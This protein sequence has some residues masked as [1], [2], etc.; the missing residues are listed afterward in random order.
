MTFDDLEHCVHENIIAMTDDRAMI[1]VQVTDLLNAL[2]EEDGFVVRRV[3]KDIAEAIAIELAVKD[4]DMVSVIGTLSAA[5]DPM[6]AWLEHYGHNGRSLRRVTPNETQIH[7]RNSL[8]N[9]PPDNEK[10]P[11]G[12]FSYGDVRNI[13]SEAATDPSLGREIALK[14][15]DRDGG[16]AKNASS[17]KPEH[18][19]RVYETF[20]RLL[21]RER[22]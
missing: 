15:L 14:V 8:S 20:E 19:D 13:V 10:A 12:K 17:V 18:L 1:S 5:L 21:N 4:G 3:A 2:D 7:L 9:T 16:G 22:G 6:I 11:G